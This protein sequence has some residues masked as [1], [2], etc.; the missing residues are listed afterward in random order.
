MSSSTTI[1]G[2]DHI[3]NI[4]YKEHATRL[5]TLDIWLPYQTQSPSQ[6]TWIIYIHGGAWR[7]PTQTSS[8]IT[9]T[10]RHL[11]STHA[12]LLQGPIAGI[13][14]INYRLS[15]YS[16]HP[17]DPSS[18][19]D[20]DRNVQHPAHVEDVTFALNYLHEKYAVQRWLGIGHSCGATLLLQALSRTYEG[21][22]NARMVKNL[23]ALIL[24]AGIYDVPLF[25]ESHTPP[26]CPADIAAIY[27]DIVRGAFGED[28]GVYAEASPVK[29]KLVGDYVVLGWSAEDVLVEKEQ[30]DNMLKRYLEKGW[31]RKGDEAEAGSEKVVEVRDLT[32]GHDEV[33]EDGRQIAGL[34]AEVV[35][36]LD[37]EKGKIKA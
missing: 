27:A 1:P 14:S 32:G 28:E 22:P 25:L 5:Q 34:V 8:G 9:P 31:V 10:I 17:T 21:D 19:D 30:R 29:G 13:A 36:R 18:P 7:D 37:G 6:G 26:R 16:S 2:L 11:Q 15:P 33:W 4:P 23:D 35:E 12:S 24:L 20:A 3:V